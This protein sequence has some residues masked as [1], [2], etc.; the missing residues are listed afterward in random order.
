MRDPFGRFEWGKNFDLSYRHTSPPFALSK[1]GVQDYH[2]VWGLNLWGDDSRE[3]RTENSFKI[4]TRKP[5]VQ[6]VDTH[7]QE[8]SAAVQM[9]EGLAHVSPRGAFVSAW[10]R[11]L[12]I[13]D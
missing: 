1:Q 2:I 12:E 7:G 8:G 11:V 4:V 13:Q 10:D 5:C 3:S 6:G 9:L